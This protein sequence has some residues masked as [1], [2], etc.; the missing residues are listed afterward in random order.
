VYELGIMVVAASEARRSSLARLLR[1]TG[2]SKGWTILAAASLLLEHFGSSHAGVL[3]ADLPSRASSVHFLQTL[4]EFPDGSGIVA[5]VD[6]PDPGWVRNALHYG[7]HAII[8]RDADRDQLALAVEAADAGYVLL[9]PTSARMLRDA[10]PA[11]PEL[12]EMTEHLTAREKEVLG[13][14]SRGLGNKEIA[15]R[16]GISEHTAKFHT[17]SI[18]AKLGAGSRTEAV[19]RGIKRGLVAL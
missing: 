7:V 2:A 1:E 9:H 15:V 18:L 3:V 19:S 10:V 12:H 5:L 14:I 17:S 16:L 11:L 13:L 6:D 8:A 4:K